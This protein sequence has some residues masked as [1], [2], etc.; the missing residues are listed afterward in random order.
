[1]NTKEFRKEL[2]KIMPGYKWTV[3]RPRWKG[4][5]SA[6]GSQSAGFN[7]ISTLQVDRIQKDEIV[8]YKAKSSGFG[9]HSPWLASME[10]GTLAQAL[11]NL[12][13]HYE[14]VAAVNASYAHALQRGRENEPLQSS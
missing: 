2:M 9:L 1:M 11:R 13:D 5:L 14:R 6:T 4:D 12:Q 3:A 10:G 8:R 7:R